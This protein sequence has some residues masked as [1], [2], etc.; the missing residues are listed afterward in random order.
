MK[1]FVHQT[2]AATT[3]AMLL[4]ANVHGDSGNPGAINFGKFPAPGK[5]GEFIEVHVGSN[6]ISMVT[7]LAGKEEP[8]VAEVLGG[9][10]EVR[11]NVIGVNE[12]NRTDLESRVKA[13]RAQLDTQGWERVVTA[14]K[15][16]DDVGVYVKTRGSDAVQGVVVMVMEKKQAVFVNVVGDLKPEKLGMIG[17]WFNI[18]PLK[19]LGGTIKK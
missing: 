16:S 18:E 3:L 5:G 19:K 2:I 15:G 7:K 6:L 9:L 12:E 17:D 8:E 4:A 10:K 14:Q 11:V 1:S 13:I